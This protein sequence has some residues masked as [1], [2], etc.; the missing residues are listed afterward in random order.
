MIYLS[1][2]L[3]YGT[4]YSPNVADIGHVFYFNRLICHDRGGQ[5][6]QRCVL[7]AGNLDLSGERIPALHNIMFHKVPLAVSLKTHITRIY[8]LLPPVKRGG[9]AAG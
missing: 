9:A 3:F 2:D 5:N 8:Y 7:C 6:C 4:H 1:P